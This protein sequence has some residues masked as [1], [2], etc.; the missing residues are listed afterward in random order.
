M[1]ATQCLVAK[2]MK[3]M[4]VKVEGEL[5]FGVTAKDIVLA[6]IGKIAPPA[7]TA[8]PSNS[9]AAPSAPCPWKAA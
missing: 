3:N 9:P 2:K 8:M 1:L 7:V 5:P 6:V 4:L